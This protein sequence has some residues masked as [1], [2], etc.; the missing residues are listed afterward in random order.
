MATSS[1]KGRIPSNPHS[2]FG[3]RESY[4]SEA[5]STSILANLKRLFD[6]SITKIPGLFRITSNYFYLEYCES[7]AIAYTKFH[8]SQVQFTPKFYEQNTKIN[9]IQ[10]CGYISIHHE[11]ADSINIYIPAYRSYDPAGLIGC[12]YVA[13][14]QFMMIIKFMSLG[15]RSSQLGVKEKRLSKIK[16][17]IESVSQAPSTMTNLWN[18]TFLQMKL[19]CYKKLSPPKYYEF[20][21]N[22]VLIDEFS[23]ENR[24][25]C[26]E[27]LEKCLRADEVKVPRAYYKAILAN[28]KKLPF[29][30]KVLYSEIENNEN[31]EE[32]ANGVVLSKLPKMVTSLTCVKEGKSY[33]K[34]LTDCERFCKIYET[35]VAQNKCKVM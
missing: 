16:K 10:Y 24:D 11:D 5:S 27:F 32:K 9:G 21:I 28:E 23:L 14:K 22:N 2:Q 17:C 15:I 1:R 7:D 29:D 19:A 35:N 12:Q 6:F 4:A 20:L 18:W 33:S 34:L 26:K 3:D 13:S 31:K 25:D 8:T 30:L